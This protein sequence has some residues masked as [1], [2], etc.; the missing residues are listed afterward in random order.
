MADHPSPAGAAGT[1]PEPSAV[2]RDVR[3]DV[4]LAAP[5]DLRRL[6][7][8]EAAADAVLLEAL[9]VTADEAGWDEPV[10]GRDRDLLPGFVLV[11]GDPPV[12]FAHVVVVDG[13]AHLEQLAVHPEHARQGI[14]AALVQAAREEAR[15][16]GHD[17]LSLTTYRDVAF[18]A[19]FYRRLGFAEVTRPSPWQERLLADERA[20]G[21]EGPGERVLLDV[22]LW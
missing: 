9:G 12:G 14:G 10:D 7:A 21:L 16:A 13:D 6:A 1:P 19:P 5:R 4:R 11:A 2:R 22:A 15:W 17:R 20:R 3:P 18:N 8:V